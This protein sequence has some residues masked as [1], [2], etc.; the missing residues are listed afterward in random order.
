MALPRY[1]SNKYVFADG[2]GGFTDVQPQEQPA[3]EDEQQPQEQQQPVEDE[4]PVEAEQP[5]EDEQPPQEPQEPK[6]KAHKGKKGGGAAV[7]L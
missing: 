4:Q 3:V 5:V 2:N 1:V 7:K 6:L